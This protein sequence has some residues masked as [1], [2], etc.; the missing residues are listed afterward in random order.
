[1]MPATGAVPVSE[2]V[3][4]PGAPPPGQ[5]VD[6]SARRNPWP[7]VLI[8]LLVVAAIVVLLLVVTGG[9][10]D[11]PTDQ[12]TTTPSQTRTSEQTPTEDTSEPEPETVEVDE[13]DY[14]GRPVDEVA[15]QLGDLGLDVSRQEVDNPGDETEGLVEGVNPSGTLA[16]GDGVTVTYWGPRPETEEPSPEPTT[17]VPTPSPTATTPTTPPSSTPTKP[18]S[19]P[20]TPAATAGSPS[21]GRQEGAG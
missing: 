4:P 19:S 6:R 17:E 13:G 16:V 7:A 9:G 1:M 5:R 21:A 15:S 14:V 3:T 11:D 12:P 2:P 20:T 8:T 10:D 18:A